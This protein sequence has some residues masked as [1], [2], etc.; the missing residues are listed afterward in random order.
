[1]RNTHP[2][3][4][5]TSK[6][7]ITLFEFQIL[8]AIVL[9]KRLVCSCKI[10]G[11]WFKIESNNVGLK[12]SFG[13][14]AHATAPRREAFGELSNV[15]YLDLS[16]KQATYMFDHMVV[17]ILCYN[18]RILVGSTLKMRRAYRYAEEAREGL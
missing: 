13:S 6:V 16:P 11:R 8:R 17:N 15:Q 18:K 4:V 9:D 2:D 5:V 7:Y 1:V 10:L 3:L 12:I 14:I